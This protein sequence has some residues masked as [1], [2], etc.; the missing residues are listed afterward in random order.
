MEGVNTALLFAVLCVQL[1]VSVR[2]LIVTNQIRSVL[3]LSSQAKPSILSE[4]VVDFPIVA[5]EPAI[6]PDCAPVTIIEFFDYFCP[7]CA[8]AQA[9]IPGIK[10][11]Y[12]DGI[13]FVFKPFPLESEGSMRFK[14]AEAALCAHEQGKF[15]E[16]HA[17][18]FEQKGSIED[19]DRLKELASRLNLDMATF[20]LC[21]DA[22][23]YAEII[24]QN[25][26]DGERGGVLGV[27]TFFINGRRFNG[28][29]TSRDY[30]VY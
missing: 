11:K 19:S 10:E 4:Q 1:F 8:E 26:V 6:G 21:L 30:T 24:R 18:L 17:L 23:K 20:S 5:G 27:P 3:Q 9:A 14:A 22:D 13:R 15:M 29:I 12:D 16:M 25:R 2:L 28:S 7:H